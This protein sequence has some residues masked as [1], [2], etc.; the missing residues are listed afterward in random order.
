MISFG[1]LFL[2]SI[3]SGNLDTLPSSKSLLRNGFSQTSI[4]ALLVSAVIK[5]RNRIRER[6]ENDRRQKVIQS[7]DSDEKKE[8]FE[9]QVCCEILRTYKAS[10]VA[11]YRV[12]SFKEHRKHSWL[13]SFY[14]DKD[15]KEIKSTG[16]NSSNYSLN[17]KESLFTCFEDVCFNQTLINHE[18]LSKPRLLKIEGFINEVY[19]P[20]ISTKEFLGITVIRWEPN[21][22]DSFFSEL[23][24][25]KDLCRALGLT[26]GSR[27]RKE[28]L[29][30]IS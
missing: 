23:R 6:G 17:I 28:Q 29:K 3:E 24:L 2:S 18:E 13:S 5:R 22:D 4:A 1:N 8:P 25:D 19:I 15:S 26:I 30:Q 11:F 21:P 9:D 20:I 7:I 14:Y 16:D 12:D 27:Y 10:E